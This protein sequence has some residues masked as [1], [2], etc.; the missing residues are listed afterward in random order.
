MKSVSP[1]PCVLFQLMSRPEFAPFGEIRTLLLMVRLPV[2]VPPLKVGRAL[3]AEAGIEEAE[4]LAQLTETV[5]PE[6]D[7]PLPQVG[8][9]LIAEV[10]MLLGTL[11][12]LVI[13]D[14]GIPEARVEG[15]IAPA[16][17]EI[18]AVDCRLRF[19]MF[20]MDMPPERAFKVT[21]EFAIEVVPKLSVVIP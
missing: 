6:L 19:E 12:Q 14:A 20:E 9:P 18:L 1:P 10:G 8:H 17:K 4:A 21:L 11:L 7:K 5:E 2:I 13:L 3:M 16:G 15:K